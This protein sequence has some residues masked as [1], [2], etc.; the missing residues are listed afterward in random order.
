[1]ANMAGLMAMAADN[2]FNYFI[3]LTGTIE[4]LRKQTSNRIYNDLNSDGNSNIHW[5]QVENPSLSRRGHTGLDIDQFDL[6]EHS[7][8]RYFSVSLKNGSRLR[9]LFKWILS[10]ESKVKQLKILLIDDEADQASINTASTIDEEY[11][12][13]NKLI[14]E[15]VHQSNVKS[16]NY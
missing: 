7:R 10:N 2:G 13:I 1:T 14:R 5:E 6:R 12:T 16:M 4:N 9:D 15:F 3:V 8:K 11:T